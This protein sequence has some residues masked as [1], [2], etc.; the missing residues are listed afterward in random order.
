MCPC[1]G[2][3]SELAEQCDDL[4]CSAPRATLAREPV[5]THPRARPPREP[6]FKF[7]FFNRLSY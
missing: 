6:P 3:E 7:A 2:D 4:P 1:S 5:L